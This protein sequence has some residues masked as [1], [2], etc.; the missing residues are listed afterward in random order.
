MDNH[1][2]VYI[3]ASK[4]NGTLYI[5]VTHDLINRVHLHKSKPILGFTAKYNVIKLVYF[6]GFEDND[7]AYKREKQLKHWKHDWKM[8]LIQKQNP[9]WNDLYNSIL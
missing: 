1:I 8:Q 4:R 5:G 9:Y 6:E 2:Y 7:L 3:L